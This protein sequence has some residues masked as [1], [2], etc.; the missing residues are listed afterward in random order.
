MLNF[1]ERLNVLT[2]E[3]MKNLNKVL[4]KK[5]TQTVTQTLLNTP[6]RCEL[7]TYLHVIMF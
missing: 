1:S 7:I 4:R 3:I 5:V 6:L 2:T